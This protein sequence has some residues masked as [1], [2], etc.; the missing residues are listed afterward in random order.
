MFNLCNSN[1]DMHVDVQPEKKKNNL[2]ATRLSTSEEMPKKKENAGY[3]KKIHTCK[4]SL[5]K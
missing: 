2:N 4:H 5:F 1:I 3:R